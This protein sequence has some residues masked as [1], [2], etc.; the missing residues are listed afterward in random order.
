MNQIGFEKESLNR[1]KMYVTTGVAPILP[2]SSHYKFVCRYGDGSWSVKD[3]KV[4]HN[5]RECIAKEDIRDTLERLWSDPFY[6]HAM[7]RRFESCIL[8]EFEE[9]SLSIVELFLATKRTSQVFKR[10]H[11]MEI[12]PINTKKPA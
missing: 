10:P 2:K 8:Q 9:I 12:T 4:M 11:R 6:S 1:I 7:P 5:G 3:N